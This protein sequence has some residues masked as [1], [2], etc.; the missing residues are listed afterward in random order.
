M[1]W[2]HNIECTLERIGNDMIYGK[3]MPTSQG[4]IVLKA[5]KGMQQLQK[6]KNALT[7]HVSCG[8]SF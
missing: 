4:K 1:L 6:P 5:I 8:K 3:R 2:L 7:G